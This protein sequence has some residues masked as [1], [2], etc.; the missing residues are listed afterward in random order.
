MRDVASLDWLPI[1][2]TPGV[3]EQVVFFNDVILQ[4]F[5]GHVPLRHG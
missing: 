5:D 1:Y 4:V 2:L 3:D